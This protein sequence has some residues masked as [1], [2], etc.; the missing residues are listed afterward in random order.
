MSEKKGINKSGNFDFVIEIC[1]RYLDEINV[2]NIIIVD[3]YISAIV[4][5]K[6][7]GEEHRFMSI[8]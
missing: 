6:I 8:S 5:K 4:D 1:T 7:V 2:P 3:D